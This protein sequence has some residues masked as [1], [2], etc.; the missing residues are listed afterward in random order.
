MVE[1][2][3]FDNILAD[4]K[5]KFVSPASYINTDKD[6]CD[7]E[8]TVKLLMQLTM[9]CRGGFKFLYHYEEQLN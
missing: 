5:P 1:V 9:T 6:I 4:F 7:F 3:R 2:L 8:N